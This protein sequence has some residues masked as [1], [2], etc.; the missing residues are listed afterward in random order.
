MDWG[1]S[2]LASSSSTGIRF[3]ILFNVR[4]HRYCFPI[5]VCNP[6]VFETRGHET[7]QGGALKFE[8]EWRNQISFSASCSLPRSSF[9]CLPAWWQVK[10]KFFSNTACERNINQLKFVLETWLSP[11]YRQSKR[12]YRRSMIG[13]F[14]RKCERCAAEETIATNTGFRFLRSGISR[15]LCWAKAENCEKWGRYGRKC[16]DYCKRQ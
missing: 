12:V 14:R 4:L 3:P 13:Q 16:F 11:F 15:A 7:H 5:P 10:W 2:S 1:K 8:L 9:F 6:R